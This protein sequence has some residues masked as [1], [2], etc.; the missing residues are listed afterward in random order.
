[1]DTKIDHVLLICKKLFKSQGKAQKSNKKLSNFRQ[2]PSKL[3]QKTS[4]VIVLQK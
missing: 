2:K 1:M 4:V 3:K